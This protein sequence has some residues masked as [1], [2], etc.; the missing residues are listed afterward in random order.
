M[1]HRARWICAAGALLV[2]AAATA[3]PPGGPAALKAKPGQLIR[4]VVK[5]DEGKLG[6]ARNFKD[7][8]AFWGELV[9]PKGQ[10]QFVFQAPADGGRNQFVVTFWTAGELDGATTTIEIEGLAP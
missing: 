2:A 5:A 4:V 1:R 10:R 3:A 9:G 8:D 7:E 6:V